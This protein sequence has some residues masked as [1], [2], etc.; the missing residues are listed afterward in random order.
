[1][2]IIIYVSNLLEVSTQ[3]H[4]YQ[5]LYTSKMLKNANYLIT[6]TPV[7]CTP[8]DI[9]TF[10][11]LNFNKEII[12]LYRKSLWLIWVSLFTVIFAN[13]P[14]TFAGICGL[15]FNRY[16]NDWEW[17][18]VQAELIKCLAAVEGSVLT[19]ISVYD[20]TTEYFISR[21]SVVVSW[22]FTCS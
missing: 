10:K 17:W 9:L 8:V 22:I 12:G 1:M 14:N 3:Q 5:V 18:F 2:D 6:S 7:G 20:S 16:I 15:V 13:D 19:I 4:A 21:N 11:D